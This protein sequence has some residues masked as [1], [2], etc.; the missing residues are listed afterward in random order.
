MRVGSWHDVHEL[1]KRIE[2][3]YLERLQIVNIVGSATK[4]LDNRE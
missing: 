3:K 1:H 4:N 2:K